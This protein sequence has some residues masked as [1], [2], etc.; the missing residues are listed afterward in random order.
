M[1]VDFAKA[2]ATA[3][4]LGHGHYDAVAN[5]R[6]PFAPEALPWRW[7]AGL[8]PAA[9]TYLRHQHGQGGGVLGRLIVLAALLGLLA[10][11]HDEVVVAVV[12]RE[13]GFAVGV[14][15]PLVAL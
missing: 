13:A 15:L 2:Q 14:G 7:Y 11:G 6:T 3:F 10:V 4:V 9:R 5:G 1:A 12:G 8:I